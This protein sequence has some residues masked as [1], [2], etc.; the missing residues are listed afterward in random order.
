M[1]A[2][3]RLG[4]ILPFLC[5]LNQ[6][7]F[8]Q[9]SEP[10]GTVN[11]D[12]A[13]R[14]AEA[15]RVER[16][17]R[18]DG[19][20]GDPVWI[21]ASP[22]TDFRQREP[23]EGQPATERTEV[24]VLYTRN[25]IYFGIACHDSAVNGPVA[26]QLRRDVTQDLDDYFEIVID[27][28]RDRRNAYVFQI[29]PLGTQRDALI[30]DEQAGDTQDGDPGWD[31]IWTSEARI[32]SDGWTA[33]VAIPFSTLNFMRSRDVVWGVNFKRFIRR[34][35]E[36]D[37]WSGWRRTFGATKISQAGELHG[38]D[39]IGS[40]RLFIVKPYVLGGFSH[41]PANATASG[42]TPGTTALHTG[43]VD[44]KVGLRSNLVAN[45]TANTD[46]AD[47]DVD[48]QQFNLTPYKL[49]F[50]EKRQFFLENAGVFAFPLGL[51]NNADQLFFSRQIGIDP[52][53][54]QQV[55]IN[56][57]AKI[58][59][60]LDG[61]ELGVIDVD[62]RSSGPNPGAN[63]AVLRL[64]RSLW[65]S[66]S[67]I[68]VMGIDKRS[69]S[70]ASMAS[71]FNQTSGADGRFVLFK[72]LVVNGYAAQTRTPGAGFSSGQSN[73]GAGLN[74]RSNWLDFEAEHRKIGPNFNPQVGFLERTDCVCD[75]ADATFK[76]RPEFAALRE[77]QFEGFIFHAPDTHGFVQTQEWQT[78]FRADFHNGSY[79]DND[80]VDVFAQRLTTHFNIY[81][82][83]NIP[84]GVYNWTRHQLTYG[85]PQDR[86][87]TV[88]FFERFGS[89]Y[90]GRLNEFR[91]RA[92]Y[93][94]NERLS[95]SVG[96]Q[97]NRFHLPLANGNFSVV[98][99]ALETDYA[100]SRFLSLST[101]LQV[102]TANAQAASAN[103]RLRWNYRPDSDLY[104]IYTAGQ[105]FASL[106]AVNPVQFYENRFVVKYT[107]S[108]RP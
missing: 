66:G 100:F 86:R 46:F 97:W 59:G 7:T 16:S 24:R 4:W 33:T 106:A 96:P 27:S 89:Y 69:G 91:V 2:R 40:G 35:N 57:G 12:L 26:T 108:F 80:I 79:T 77:L 15:V 49:F 18:L 42:L 29:N 48:V 32:T 1:R 36:E 39:E 38:I 21:Q 31:G 11:A 87:L 78:T 82:N 64:K 52:I 3:A 8:G 61:F 76:A 19:T 37:L 73:L 105:K 30:T 58:T 107:Y 51:G 85:S 93:R 99:G 94:A 68:G 60:S 20:L 53:T 17:P 75:F 81:K 44:I 62:T 10:V 101:I 25:E 83:V 45:L 22:I 84:V 28:R 50:P 41:L 95:F 5:V 67:Y 98:F 13:E 71:S 14:I 102:D 92:T 43:G 23:Y 74:F 34:K 9:K 70:V 103:I 104:V 54:G 88:R 56:G 72:D 55:P 63:Y 65:G 47:S 6:V 90:N